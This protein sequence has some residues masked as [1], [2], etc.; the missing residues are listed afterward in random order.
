MKRLGTDRRGSFGILTAL[1]M[2]LLLGA[3]GGAVD[4]AMAVN[5]R[6][7]NQWSL[8]AGL[9]AAASESGDAAQ[10]AR[11]LAFLSPLAAAKGGPTMDEIAA[12]LDVGK[13]AD[14]N[15]TG[16]L[17]QTYRTTFL[18]ILGINSF[19]ITVSSAV[20]AGGS[21]AP[22]LWVLAN[23]SQ[24]LLT[25][26]GATIKSAA[27]AVNVASPS[28]T[29]FF[30]NSGVTVDVA[31]FC[32]RAGKYVNNGGFVRNMQTDCTPDPDPYAGKIPDPTVPACGNDGP[33]NASTYTVP[34]GIHCNLNFNG[35]P[36]LTFA[37]G[38][39]IIK[40][41]MTINSGATVAANG[42]TFY[43]PDA[44]SKIQ[45][46]GTVAITASAPTSGTYKGILM[47]EKSSGSNA[48]RQLVFNGTKGAATLQGV[49]YLPRG[50][51]SS[52]RASTRTARS[53]WS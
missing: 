14:G 19:P 25:N 12:G 24:T 37:P 30:L 38:L 23:G 44:D 40:G 15:L 48:T 27:C 13:D 6:E 53:R 7:T 16:S 26:S 45:F 22:C 18:G 29:G 32:L 21:P 17:T 50:M 33:V 5:V 31:K 43:F 39:H 46:N 10:R 11:V 2:P 20:A 3:A 47:F 9:L 51:S 49:I 35:S 4:F 8:D 34:A 42:V 36:S 41:T 28:S 1:L 52:T